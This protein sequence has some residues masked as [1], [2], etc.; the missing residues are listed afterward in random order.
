MD[1]ADTG[2]GDAS[3]DCDGDGGAGPGEVLVELKNGFSENLDAEFFCVGCRGGG[4][5]WE[6]AGDWGTS[7]GN[8]AF[9]HKLHPISAGG[10]V[11]LARMVEEETGSMINSPPT[12]AEVTPLLLSQLRSG[13][14][15]NR[16]VGS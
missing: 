11:V 14:A 13:A 16:R 2:L 15:S 7:V 8:T 6:A 1:P 5:K 4:P 3:G 12:I 9:P 10:V